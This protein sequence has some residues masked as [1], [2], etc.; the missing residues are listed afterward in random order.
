MLRLLRQAPSAVGVRRSRWTLKLLAQH[1]PSLQGVTSCSG[2]SRR[3]RS[4]K[5]SYKRGRS[6]LWSPDPADGRK[7]RRIRSLV[8]KARR[9]EAVVLFADEKTFYRQ[10]TVGKAWAET[11][12]G[13]RSQATTRRACSAN[14]TQR[15]V[16]ALNAATGRLVFGS[17]PK[18]GVRVLQGFLRHIRHSY[19]SKAEI[20]LIWDN[21]PVH[22]HEDVVREAAKQNITLVWLPAYAPWL[23]PIE[24]LW[25]KLEEEVLRMHRSSTQWEPLKDLVWEFLCTFKRPRRSLLRYVGLLPN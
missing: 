18:I 11:G 9:G 8:A 20:F 13:G 25:K 10:P 4:W 1:C 19:G 2:V 21:W 17:A 24:K 6:R 7:A 14:H 3:L 12:S 16:G 22:A 15:L 23:N 5:L